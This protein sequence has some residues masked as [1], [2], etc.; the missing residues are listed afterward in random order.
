MRKKELACSIFEH[1]TVCITGTHISISR[2]PFW[3][4]AQSPQRLCH[5]GLRIP[6]YIELCSVGC[7]GA[8]LPS[9]HQISATHP[10]LTANRSLDINKAP[11]EKHRPDIPSPVHRTQGDFQVNSEDEGKLSTERRGLSQTVESMPVMKSKV[12]CARQSVLLSL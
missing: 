4:R 11:Y 3:P 5:S 6:L 2:R 8:S 1:Q 9:S 12:V 7:S 10:Q